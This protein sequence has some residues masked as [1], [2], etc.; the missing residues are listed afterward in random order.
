M[1]GRG[2]SYALGNPFENPVAHSAPV[3]ES[4]VSHYARNTHGP[5]Y[6]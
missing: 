5:Y 2:L 6:E 1:R 4:A 3:Q